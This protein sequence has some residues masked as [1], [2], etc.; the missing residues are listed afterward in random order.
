MW[1]S[2]ISW[3]IKNAGKNVFLYYT[4]TVM[5]EYGPVSSATVDSTLTYGTTTW[6]YSGLTDS[7][8][9]VEFGRKI[10]TGDYIAEVT[11][12]SHIVYTYNSTRDIDNPITYPE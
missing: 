9:K 11:G 10:G 4:V 12:I 6:S 8:G 5:S 1:V 3:R 2:D 7:N